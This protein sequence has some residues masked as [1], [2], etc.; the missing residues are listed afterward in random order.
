MTSPQEWITTTKAIIVTT[1]PWKTTPTTNNTAQTM[2]MAPVPTKPM[3][4]AP[5]IP[6]HLLPTI[7]QRITNNRRWITTM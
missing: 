4:T 6:L 7:L 1:Q 2:N 5:D 3:K